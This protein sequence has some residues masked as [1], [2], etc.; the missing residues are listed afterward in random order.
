MAQLDDVLISPAGPPFTYLG[1]ASALS[2]AV[3]ALAE[4]PA[5]TKALGI[6]LMAAHCLECTLKAFLSRG[7]CDK[8]LKESPLRHDLMALWRL[9]H[10]EGLAI[11]MPPPDWVENLAR[12]HN[13]PY[14]LRYSTGVHGILLP[15]NQ[16]M[17]DQLAEILNLVRKSI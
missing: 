4:S 17:A 1:V 9:S 15:A 11:S 14:Y 5:K 6:S 13:S 12:L 8:R 7:G 3:N 2:S 16:P 10:E